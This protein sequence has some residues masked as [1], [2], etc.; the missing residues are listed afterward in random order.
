[1][2][3]NLI[4]FLYLKNEFFIDKN[5]IIHLN[6]LKY[7][8]N[9]FDGKVIIT[10]SSDSEIKNK[11]NIKN[12]FSFFKDPI[13]DFIDNDQQLRESKFFREQVAHLESDES[14]TFY[15]HSKGTTGNGEPDPLLNWITSMYYFNLNDDIIN[16]VVEFLRD[17]YF[18]GTLRKEVSCEPWV[19]SPWHYSGTF[20]WFNTKKILSCDK[21]NFK[22]GRFEIESF[23]GNVCQIEGS[24]C[25]LR[26]SYDYNFDARYSEFWNEIF[27]K[28][29]DSEILEFNRLKK[30]NTTLEITKI[31]NYIG[32]DKG[33]VIDEAH[34]YSEIYESLFHT[35][36]DKKINIIEIGIKDPRF[37]YASVKAW[38]LYFNN[39]SILGLDIMNSSDLEHLMP[40]FKYQYLDQYSIES[41][42]SVKNLMS[43]NLFDI[44]I[45]DGPHYFEAQLNSLNLLYDL[46]KNGGYYIIEDIHVDN[47]ILDYLSLRR[48]YKYELFCNNKL[49]VITK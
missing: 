32:S 14:I 13:I 33:T 37:P 49:I 23:P 41:H 47:R 24:G 11:E 9:I 48:D 26:F 28:F 12:L 6:F 25:D 17:N 31:L 39:C 29:T 20:F 34:S 15:C 44:I 30:N 46:L 40:N 7:Y 2:K 4:F 8:K 35:M 10:I 45:D 36:K 42:I 27:S 1:M 21:E 18:Y 5:T 43:G 38:D 19:S 16:T 3:K 22:L